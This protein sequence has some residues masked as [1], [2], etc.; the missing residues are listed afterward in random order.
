MLLQDIEFQVERQF[1]KVAELAFELG[2]RPVTSEWRSKVE[3]YLGNQN[4]WEA[5]RLMMSIR[6]D[7]SNHLDKIRTILH[8]LDL[9][10]KSR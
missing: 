9:Q 7:I 6:Q 3:N 4:Y 10:M 5:V 2:D 1:P 8:E